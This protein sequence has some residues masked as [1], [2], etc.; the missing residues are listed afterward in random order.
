MRAG[1]FCNSR[2]TEPK[3]AS[4]LMLV[5]RYNKKVSNDKIELVKAESQRF[6]VMV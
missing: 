2:Q 6:R 4:A 3:I 5:S 1:E